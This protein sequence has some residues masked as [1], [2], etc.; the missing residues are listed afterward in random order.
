V[1]EESG[2]RA[3]E[4][5][6]AIAKAERIPLERVTLDSTFEELGIDSL[7]GFSLLFDIEEKFDIEID[8]ADA[9][10]IRDVR[11]LLA[12]VERRVKER[13]AAAGG[14]TSAGS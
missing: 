12:V 2:T 9:R 14:A 3:G 6:A 11:G 1:S 4:V 5:L 10:Q 13:D 8:D 7:D